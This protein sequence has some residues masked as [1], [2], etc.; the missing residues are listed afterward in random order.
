MELPKTWGEYLAWVGVQFPV[1]VLLLLACRW[2][3]RHFTRE[4]ANHVREVRADCD[5]MLADKDARIA[6]RERENRRLNRRVRELERR[7]TRR[8][9][10]KPGDAGG[11]EGA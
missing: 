10:R 6:D 4:H 11:G 2:I 8:P 1:A 9:R 5:R 7:L 3:I